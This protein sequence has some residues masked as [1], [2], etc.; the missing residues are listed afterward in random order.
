[1]SNVFYN[2][3]YRKHTDFVAF[4][5]AGGACVVG[6]VGGGR[7]YASMSLSL[8]LSLYVTTPQR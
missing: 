4:V 5:R 1:M 6:V 2:N 3:C 7:G 8:Y